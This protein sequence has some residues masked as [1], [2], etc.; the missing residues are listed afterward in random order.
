MSK[1][2]T[3]FDKFRFKIEIPFLPSAFRRCWS[4]FRVRWWERKLCPSF[5]LWICACTCC[6]TPVTSW[7]WNNWEIQRG[8]KGSIIWVIE[9][10]NI[11][12]KIVNKNVIKHKKGLIHTVTFLTPRAIHRIFGKNRPYPLPL[13]SSIENR[14]YTCYCCP[15]IPSMRTLRNLL[16]LCCK[17]IEDNF[18]RKDL[19]LST[20]RKPISHFFHLTNETK[21]LYLF[22]SNNIWL[23]IMLSWL[24]WWLIFIHKKLSSQHIIAFH[25]IYLHERIYEWLDLNYYSFIKMTNQNKITFH[26]IYLHELTY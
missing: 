22:I 24:S 10:K 3:K 15:Y 7:T 2:L 19:L 9:G 5:S 20:F 6:Y 23:V 21:Y 26:L 12:I 16:T 11:M 17:T 18:H 14:G 4:S 13:L 25:L 1:I 8:V